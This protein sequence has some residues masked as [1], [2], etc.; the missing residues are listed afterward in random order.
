MPQADCTAGASARSAADRG[1]AR[2]DAL[3]GEVQAVQPDQ[4]IVDFVGV[5]AV[6]AELAPQLLQLGAG[7]AAP[8]VFVDE[9]EHF[10]HASI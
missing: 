4:R 6:G 9:N 8:V 2:R 10:K 3:R 7:I 1:I 5:E